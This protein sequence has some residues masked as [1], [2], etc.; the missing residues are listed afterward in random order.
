MSLAEQINDDFLYITSM[1]DEFAKTCTYRKYED[2]TQTSV[3]AVIDSLQY[4][5]IHNEG[6][7][8]ND[9]GIAYLKLDFE[10]TVYD[11][12]IVDGIEWQVDSFGAVA[13]GY[14][15]EISKGNVATT[16]HTKGRFR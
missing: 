8:I 5:D 1:S 10:P 2:G 6:R 11:K 7:A 14:R 9:N 13:D 3:S 4:K 16:K 15:L 12:L